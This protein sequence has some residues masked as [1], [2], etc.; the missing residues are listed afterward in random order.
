MTRKSYRQKLFVPLI[1]LVIA[2]ILLYGGLLSAAASL[3]ANSMTAESGKIIETMNASGYTYLLIDS[4]TARTWVAIPETTVKVG[5]TVHYANGMIMKDFHSKTLNR[6]FA[7]V[8]FSPGL[9]DQAPETEKKGATASPTGEKASKASPTADD[10]SFSAA[11][12]AE[13]QPEPAMT[14]SG[15]STGAIVPFA[16]IKI[17]K[18]EGE[19]GH[20]VLE[21]FKQAKEL[22]GKVV[23]LRGMVMKVNLNIMGKNWVHLQDGTGDPMTNTHDLVITT[24]ETPSQGQTV[25]VEGTMR[26]AKDFGAGYSY[27]AIIEDA[28]IVN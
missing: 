19:N 7:S 28:K 10:S 5:D 3:P 11:V 20:T 2:A 21:I 12:Q 23:R 1:P 13:T 18:A 24:A 9:T 27:A 26:A 15:G 16:E 25:T 17:E 8:V 4:G 6:T 14:T 22:D